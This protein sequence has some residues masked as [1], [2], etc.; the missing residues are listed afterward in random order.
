MRDHDLRHFH[1]SHALELNVPITEVSARA[2]HSNLSFTWKVYAHLLPGAEPGAPDAIDT[3]MEQ[4]RLDLSSDKS[5]NGE[6][7]DG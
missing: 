2:G 5:G 6:P 1:V 7:Q 4:F 3:A